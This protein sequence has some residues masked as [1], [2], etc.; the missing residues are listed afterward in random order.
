MSHYLS[1]HFNA[2]R[3]LI[4][5]FLLS[6]PLPSWGGSDSAISVQ[7]YEPKVKPSQV[8][9]LNFVKLIGRTEPNVWVKVN[10]ENIILIQRSNPDSGTKPKVLTPSV[11]SNSKGLFKLLLHMPE[12]LSQVSI[13]FAKTLR[14]SQSVL[15]TMRVDSADASLNVKVIRPKTKIVKVIKAPPAKYSFGVG[16]APV[17]FRENLKIDER[18][19]VDLDEFL[20]SSIRFDGAMKYTKWWWISQYEFS[21]GDEFNMQS[22]LLGG[23]YKLMQSKQELWVNLDVDGRFYPLVAVNTSDAT[24]LV[25][26]QIFRM[27]IGATYI[28]HPDEIT[29]SGTIFYREPF[30]LKVDQGEIVY[31]SRFTFGVSGEIIIPRNESWSYGVMVGLEH[32]SFKY[33]YNNT[34][35]LITNDGV[36]G[37][38]IFQVMAKVQFAFEGEE[39]KSKI[40]P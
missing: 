29:Y 37:A 24:S 39:K 11:K 8:S 26:L 22:V 36:G 12:G 23:R 16:L 25:D 20:P 5:V 2:F 34:P 18:A 4:T 15:L 38:T 30:T 35:N 7:W 6:V 9:D 27:G 33:E 31:S 1:M 40:R 10:S 28:Y 21:K 32:S 13:I 14:K 17:M 3:W 19:D